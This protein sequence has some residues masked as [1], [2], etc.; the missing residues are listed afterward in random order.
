MQATEK[1]IACNACWDGVEYEILKTFLFQ[2][3]QHSETVLDTDLVSPAPAVLPCLRSPVLR[4]RWSQR[5]SLQRRH[6]RHQPRHPGQRGGGA[7]PGAGVHRPHQQQ[8][9]RQAVRRWR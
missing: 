4:V 6:R 7:G 9:L 1:I 2:A 8:R 5:D 3:L